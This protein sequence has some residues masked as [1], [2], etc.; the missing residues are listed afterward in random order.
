MVLRQLRSLWRQLL[1]LEYPR[2]SPGIWRNR[3]TVLILLMCALVALVSSWPWLTEPN[4]RPGM[5]A[6][7]TVRAPQAAKV[8]DSNALEERRQQLVPRSTVQV[9]DEQTNR[10]LRQKLEQ[11]LQ[12]V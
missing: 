8:V 4:L 11:G 9:V 6:P 2:Q 12:A 10:Q 5:E 3:D 7:F 1:R